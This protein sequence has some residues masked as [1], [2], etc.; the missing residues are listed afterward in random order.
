[1]LI[2]CFYK[3]HIVLGNKK[4]YLLPVGN[5][6]IIK[7]IIDTSVSLFIVKVAIQKG[8]DHRPL[9]VRFICSFLFR[10]YEF[11]VHST[12]F[13]CTYFSHCYSYVAFFCYS[14]SIIFLSKGSICSMRFTTNALPIINRRLFRGIGIISP[15]TKHSFVQ[16]VGNP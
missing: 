1:M 13:P 5:K 10:W 9:I 11:L 15:L 7:L 14:S 2:N 6:H 3:M 12:L 8:T 16:S 4:A